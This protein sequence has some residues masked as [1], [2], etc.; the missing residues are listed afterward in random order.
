M[1]RTA[2]E[3]LLGCIEYGDLERLLTPPSQEVLYLRG[4]ISQLWTKDF[5][6]ALL[7]Y[8]IVDIPT[9]TSAET[10]NAMKYVLDT[11]GALVI[12]VP[13]EVSQNIARKCIYVLKKGRVPVIGIVENL[14]DTH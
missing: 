14:S 11:D 9:G 6:S 1:K 10:I 7:D 4:L 13:T 12:T 8:L 3:E 2:T 5:F